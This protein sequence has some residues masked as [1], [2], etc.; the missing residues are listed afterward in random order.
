MGICR[1]I[2]WPRKLLGF[3]DL[4]RRLLERDCRAYCKQLRDPPLKKET[5]P[6]KSN[7]QIRRMVI[8]SI[9]SIGRMFKDYT[10]GQIPADAI[11]IKLMF[12]PHNRGKLAILMSSEE[13]PKGE[14]GPVEVKF[15]FK[16]VFGVGGGAQ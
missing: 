9:D 3:A 8:T 15:E 1:D 10:Q 13:W 6:M 2:L 12:Q 11:P 16:R 14:T 7:E 5:Q 4:P